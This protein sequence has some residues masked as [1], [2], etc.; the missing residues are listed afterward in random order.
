MAQVVAPTIQACLDG[1]MMT[2]EGLRAL[3]GVGEVMAREILV[4]WM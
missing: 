1:E 3:P 4:W 2:I